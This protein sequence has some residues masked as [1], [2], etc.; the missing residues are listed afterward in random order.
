MGWGEPVLAVRATQLATL[1]QWLQDLEHLHTSTEARGNLRAALDALHRADLPGG[2]EGECEKC[3]WVEVTFT[4]LGEGVS[5]SG[6]GWTQRLMRATS[7]PQEWLGTDHPFQQSLNS[8]HH[9]R[10]HLSQ[11]G[12]HYLAVWLYVEAND[13]RTL[14][15]PPLKATLVVRQ[16]HTLEISHRAWWAQFWKLVFLRVEEGECNTVNRGGLINEGAAGEVVRA[17]G[18]LGE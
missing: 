11:A 6:R 14:V 1:L 4:L 9:F 15:T 2:V 17:F 10:C 7:T 8:L 3:G 16:L 13:S 18:F 12:G 5:R